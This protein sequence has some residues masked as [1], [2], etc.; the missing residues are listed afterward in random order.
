MVALPGRSQVLRL[1]PASEGSQDH[2]DAMLG[3][4]GGNIAVKLENL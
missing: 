2:F 4:G 1:G 3:G